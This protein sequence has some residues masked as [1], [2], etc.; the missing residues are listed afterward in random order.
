MR[1]NYWQKKLAKSIF[2]NKSFV[3]QI[4]ESIIF[5]V[6]HDFLIIRDSG[7]PFYGF[8]ILLEIF[9]LTENDATILRMLSESYPISGSVESAADEL[10]DRWIKVIDTDLNRKEK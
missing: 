5:S 8:T 2:V 6:L 9:D 7:K 10:T 3:L 1:K 4:K